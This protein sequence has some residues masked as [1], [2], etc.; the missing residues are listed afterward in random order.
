MS[1]LVQAKEY[2]E[3]EENYLNDRLK[4]C[5]VYFGFHPEDEANV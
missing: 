5:T 2:C 3:I 1:E 4:A